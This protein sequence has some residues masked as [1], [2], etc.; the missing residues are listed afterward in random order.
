MERRS[1]ERIPSSLPVEVFVGV[2]K[3]LGTCINLS[4]EGALLKLD[5]LWD[6]DPELSLLIDPRI[7]SDNL[8]KPAHVVRATSPDQ[9]GTF[10]AVRFRF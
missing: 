1:V 10:L 6:G 9:K 5:S 7:E 2:K 8:P 4:A 3:W